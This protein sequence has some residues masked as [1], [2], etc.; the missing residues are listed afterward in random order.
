M[1]QM[2]TASASAWL[3]FT[4]FIVA[5]ALTI[6]PLPN[7][8]EAFRPEWV[9]LAVIYWALAQPQSVGVGVGWIVGLLLDIVHGAVFGQHALGMIFVAYIVVYL[10]QRIRTYPLWQQL[11]SVLMLVILYKLLLLWIFGVIGRSLDGFAYWSS[12]LTSVL[13]WPWLSSLLRRRT[14]VQR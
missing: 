9:V 7:D 11:L 10:H 5:F 8:I 12:V 3:I 14:A 6:I 13:L 1:T 2:H 4:S